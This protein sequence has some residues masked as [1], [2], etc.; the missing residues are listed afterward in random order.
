M[1]NIAGTSIP[2]RDPMAGMHN[3]AS[4]FAEPWLAAVLVVA[5]LVTA[6]VAGLALAAFA[7][8]RSRSY[9]LVAL[10]FVTLFARTL[11]AG[12]TITGVLGGSVHHLLEHGLDV[13]MALLVIGAVF[14]ARSVESRGTT[15]VPYDD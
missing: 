15:E 4:I 12:V 5:G 13:I 3:G 2:H 9:L 8:R 11:V 14:Y 7:R 10:A 1:T 6:I